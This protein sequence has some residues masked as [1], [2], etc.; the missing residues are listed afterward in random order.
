M[1]TAKV[2][3]MIRNEAGKRARKTQVDFTQ[4]M[5]PKQGK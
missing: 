4:F 1:A 3:K 5:T 2:Q